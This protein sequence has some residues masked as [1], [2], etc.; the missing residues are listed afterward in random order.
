M[1]VKKLNTEPFKRWPSGDHKAVI[2]LRLR[3]N[4]LVKKVDLPFIRE[5]DDLDWGSFAH[6]LDEK[7]GPVMLVD[8]ENSPIKGVDI[9]VDKSVSN[10]I[11][12]DRIRLVLG[13][14]DDDI[15]WCIE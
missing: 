4:E 14:N 12:I 3:A 2:Q 9:H 11:A 5:R 1:G 10:D 8:Y 15:N 7:I 13:L 6:F